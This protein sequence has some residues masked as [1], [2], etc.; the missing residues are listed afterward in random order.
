[1]NILKIS[2]IKILEKKNIVKLCFVF[3]L[4]LKE[5]VT[6]KKLSSLFN[7]FATPIFEEK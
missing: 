7:G 4:I 5:N 3:F 2:K 6:D 1:M